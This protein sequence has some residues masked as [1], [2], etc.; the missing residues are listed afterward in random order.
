MWT[1]R[2]EG[3]EFSFLLNSEIS[4]HD[5]VRLYAYSRDKNDSGKYCGLAADMDIKRR[6]LSV[7]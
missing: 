2:T 4:N 3:R 7:N 6:G 1:V 5:L